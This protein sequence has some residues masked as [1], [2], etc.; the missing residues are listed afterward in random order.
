M[1]TQVA[2][3]R[4]TRDDPYLVAGGQGTAC[5]DANEIHQEVVYGSGGQDW[6]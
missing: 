3:L 6:C 2:G 5:W 4:Q 1:V